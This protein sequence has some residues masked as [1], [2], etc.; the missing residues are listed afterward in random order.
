MNIGASTPSRNHHYI[1]QCYLRGFSKNGGKK[2]MLTVLDLEKK[3]F[4]ET[5]TRNIGAVRDFNRVEIK[6][7]NPDFLENSLSG[8]EGQTASAIKNISATER[9]EGN[10]KI[11]ILNLIALLAIRTPNV[12]ENRRMNH[13]I[14]IKRTMDIALSSNKRYESFRKNMANDGEIYSESI[15][16]EDVKQFHENGRYI[17]EL[18]SEIHIQTEFASID[19][20][21]P[22]LFQRKWLLFSAKNQDPLNFIT[23]DRPVVLN[24]CNPQ[25]VGK[26]IRNY[27]G[28]GLNDTEV[29]FPISKSLF[30]HGEFDGHEG[31]R[32]ADDRLIACMNTKMIMSAYKQVYS[33]TRRFLFLADDFSIQTGNK[34][35]AN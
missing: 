15:T 28:Y 23:T 30:L 12:R 29:I 8:F 34:L 19:T 9:F 2:S 32:Y 25:N 31:T 33:S 4:F 11:A 6:G 18:P 10:D 24:W 27:P 20:V 5:S 21:L 7:K 13:E 35:F 3:N 16:Y 1:P 26:A 17:I 22:Y 14:L